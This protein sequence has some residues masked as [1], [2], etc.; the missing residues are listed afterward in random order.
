MLDRR[1]EYWLTLVIGVFAAGT[2]MSQ[3]IRAHR[4]R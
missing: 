4:G 3:A 2:W 1:F